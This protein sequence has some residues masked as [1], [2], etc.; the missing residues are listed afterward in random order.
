MRLSS[1]SQVVTTDVLLLSAAFLAY[2]G[3]YAVRKSFLAGQ[4]D[5][6]PALGNFHFKTLLIISQVLGYMLSK[7]IG[8]K[9]VSEV[10]G[11]R[12]LRMLLGLVGFGLLTL[13]AFAWLPVSLKP[14]ALFLNGL[15]L[16][17][18][19]GLVLTYLEGRRHTELLVA[20][21]SATFI[22]STGLV[23]TTGLW[24]MQQFSV[25]ELMMPFVTG[26]LFFPVFLLAIWL[27][28]LSPN[29]N[30]ADIVHRVQ[31]TPMNAS[32]RRDFLRRHGMSFAGL[33]VIYILLTVA[34]DFRD[35]FIVEFWAELDQ[36]QQPALITLTEIPI[37]VIVV[38]ICALGIFIAN[39]R[40][41]FNIGLF[42]TSLSALLMLLLTYVFQQGWMSPTVW[43]ISSG[44]SI[45]LPYILF[46]CLIFERF[47]A[48]LRYPGTVGFL[49]YVADASGYLISV[50]ILII[51][52]SVSL[53]YSWVDFFIS[54]NQC[55]AVGILIVV[56]VAV[57]VMLK[58]EK[59]YYIWSESQ[60]A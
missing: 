7:F 31:R 11:S 47:I 48:L 20:G 45:Y 58:Q 5:S 13:L 17:M 51:K 12:R 33:V 10:S 41:A 60:P 18:V 52:E 56:S 42:A 1:K 22:F 15:P 46:H 6:L 50:A 40:I 32:Q 35:N 29:P 53:S 3:M 36:I 59:H 21:L 2:T 8:I 44:T 25:S 49:F 30:A 57:M 28:H 55:T 39:N 24:L 14:L 34:R 37:A 19:F 23:K 27:L 43:I 4:F 54:L 26:S 38:T 9:V 16:G